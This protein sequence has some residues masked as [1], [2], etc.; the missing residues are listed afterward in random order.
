MHEAEDIGELC[1]NVSPFA[2]DLWDEDLNPI[3]C[4]PKMLELFGLNTQE[5]YFSRFFELAPAYQPDGTL[6]AVKAEGQMRLALR[7]GQARFEFMHC[8]V[9]GEPLPADV[10]IIRVKHKGKYMLIGYTVDLRPLKAAEEENKIFLENNPMFIEMWDHEKNLVWCS[11]KTLE[12]FSFSEK[13]EYLRRHPELSPPFQPCGTASAEKIKKLLGTAFDNGYARSEWIHIHPDTGNP[14]PFEITLVRAKK[15]GKDVVLGYNH[16]LRPIKWAIDNQRRADAKFSQAQE[17]NNIILDSCPLCIE[18]WDEEKNLIY[19]NQKI[20][21]YAHVRS[22][23]EY[24]ESFYKQQIPF[25]PDTDSVVEMQNMLE[26]AINEGYVRFECEYKEDDGTKVYYETQM[27]RI[28]RNGRIEILSYSTDLSLVK[29]T[30]GEIREADERAALMLDATPLACFLLRPFMIENTKEDAAPIDCNQ[31]AVDL[32]GFS[33]K[34]AAIT[35]YHKIFAIPEGKSYEDMWGIRWENRR[36]TLENG[37]HRFKHAHKHMNGDIIPCEIIMVRVNY[38]GEPVVACF[39]NDLRQVEAAMAKEREAFLL[40]Q[41]I[42]DSAPFA[43]N[44]WDDDYNI[45][46]SNKKAYEFYELDENTPLNSEFFNLSPDF[47]PCGTPSREKAHYYLKKAYDNGYAQFEWQHQTKEGAPRPTEITLVRSIYKDKTMLLSYTFDLRNVRAAEEF[48]LKILD[49]APIFMELWDL[50]GKLI[51]CNRR[52]QELFVVRA[53]KE[54]LANFNKCYT[55]FQ[56]CGTPTV[57][58]RKQMIERAVNEGRFSGDEWLYLLPDGERLP[59]EATWVYCLQ[60]DK[61]VVLVYAHDLRPTKASMKRQQELEAQ[62]IEQEA[63]AYIRQVFDAA[64]LMI[65]YWDRFGNIIDC[66]QTTLKYYGY[67]TKEEYKRNVFTYIDSNNGVISYGSKDKWVKQ[68]SKIY[69]KGYGSF[70]F[71]ETFRGKE[72]FHEVEGIAIN[73]NNEN[74]IITFTRDV[75]IIKELQLER[76]RIEVAEESNRAK[77]RFLARMSHEIR[78]PITAV[79]GI[80]EIHLQNPALSPVLEESFAKIHD[81]SLTLLNIVNDI[82]DLSRIESGKMSLLCE[83]YEVASLIADSVQPHFI[84][85][86]YKNIEFH[87]DVDP[88]LPHILKGDVLRIKQIINNI[89]SNAFKYTDNGYINLSIKS[90]RAEEAFPKGFINLIINVSDTGVGM[91][92]EQLDVIYSDYA[93]FHEHKARTAPGTGLGM[94][95]VYS[96]VQMMGASINVESEINAGTNVSVNIPQEIVGFATLGVKLAESLQR[97]EVGSHSSKNKFK[98]IPEPMPYGK[99]LIVDDVSANLYVVSGLLAFYDLNIETCDS[100]YCALEKIEAGNVYDIVLMDQMMPGINGTETMHKMRG[101][102][103]NAPIVALTANALIGQAEQFISEGFDGFISKPIQTAQ[104]NSTLVRHIK[105]KQPPEVIAA[106]ISGSTMSKGIFDYQNDSALV[107]KLRTGFAKNEKNMFR[108]IMAALAAGD[109]D[110]AQLKAHSLKGLAALMQEANLAEAAKTI[111]HILEKAKLPGVSELSALENE[112]NRVISSIAVIKAP[113]P[114]DAEKLES[115][116]KAIDILTKL[117]PVLEQRNTE[118]LSMLSELRPIPEAAILVRQIE[119]F[120]FA[121]ALKSLKTLLSLWE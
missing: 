21:D 105:N 7:E 56:P 8:T 55:E 23:E 121:T 66:N 61:P 81:S 84:N 40:A 38:K 96:L 48:T 51:D 46:E 117:K 39:Q 44:R 116:D 114:L 101:L 73:Y 16:D 88:D 63:D 35:N 77:G 49:N 80:S 91:S 28:V 65:E 93:R 87:V 115:K 45:A 109:F 119:G 37:V 83:E 118:C 5:E 97:F 75:T 82:L 102:G 103:Y 71:N 2:I 36:I 22:F 90:Q 113:I 4:N 50:E 3:Y 85:L 104:L 54:L 18:I 64:P 25:W 33:D 24:K 67:P 12:F 32:F 57:I 120:D 43:I 92:K 106:A 100:G 78:T 6:S 19:C 69:N 86:G 62:L 11:E 26:I 10:T 94:P 95:I 13:D 58:K 47:Q 107:E 79:L 60:N 59:V 68:L 70:K 76:Q 9:S 111:E 53:K 89:L 31:A 42:L 30:M 14:L 27:F 72:V 41:T 98:F 99:V 74:V 108:D 110:K 15:A 112:F 34:E 1:M 29:R 52:F 20:L 17:L